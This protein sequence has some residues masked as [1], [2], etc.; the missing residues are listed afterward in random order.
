MSGAPILNLR[1]GKVCAMMTRTRDARTDG[2]GWAIPLARHFD[3][4]PAILGSSLIPISEAWNQARHAELFQ[5]FTGVIH[6]A[7]RPL[8]TREDLPPSLLLRTEYATVP[9]LGRQHEIEELIRWCESGAQS[10]V[11]LLVGPA[12]A[13]KTRLA[14]QLC[15]EMSHRGWT[16]GF[17]SQ[18]CKPESFDRLR[19]TGSPLLTVFD[20]SDAWLGLE[21]FLIRLDAPEETA[22]PTR[23]VLL[24]RHSGAWWHRMVSANLYVAM[25]ATNLGAATATPDDL[26][27]AYLKSAEA[28]RVHL[29]T[30]PIGPHEPIPPLAGQPMLVVHMAALLR[31]DAHTDQRWLSKDQ[32]T[33]S[34]SSE[35]I[36]S[37]LDHEETYWQRSIVAVG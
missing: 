13:G 33:Q 4:F 36:G 27:A 15:R 20:Y 21:Q 5:R 7:Y 22:P 16:A 14:A 10:S 24:A 1:T 25:D 23:I 35:I 17:L 30:A 34:Q 6:P 2:G 26:R 12:G 28:F 19:K 37:I 18:S 3:R 9:F 29:D 32:I 11:R 31:V 8:P